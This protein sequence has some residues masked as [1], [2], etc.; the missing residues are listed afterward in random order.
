MSQYQFSTLEKTKRGRH[1]TLSSLLKRSFLKIAH[2][3]DDRRLQINLCLYQVA[4]ICLLQRLISVD[5]DFHNVSSHS[6]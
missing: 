4:P 6:Y 5:L 3:S 1:P 2:G